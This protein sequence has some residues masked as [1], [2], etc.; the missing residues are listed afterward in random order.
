MEKHRLDVVV[1]VLEAAHV[2][3]NKLEVVEAQ[4]VVKGLLVL[5]FVDVVDVVDAVVVLVLLSEGL[6]VAVAGEGYI[7]GLEVEP[8]SLRVMEGS[9]RGWE[10]LDHKRQLHM[11][12]G[13]Q[14]EVALHK[15]PGTGVHF[16]E[17]AQHTRLGMDRT[18]RGRLADVQEV[19]VAGDVADDSVVASPHCHRSYMD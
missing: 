12:R 4:H 1:V 15:R 6:L 16:G 11:N 8:Q 14:E 13:N 5:G 2:E 9:Q 7:Q 19:V 10:V 3:R 17:L 18:G